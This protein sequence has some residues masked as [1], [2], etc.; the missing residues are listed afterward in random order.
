MAP[1]ASNFRYLHDLPERKSNGA[2]NMSLM[3]LINPEVI[4]LTTFPIDSTSLAFSTVLSKDHYPYPIDF[5]AKFP[6]KT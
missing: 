2:P 1:V 3:T 6:C 4:E 5:L